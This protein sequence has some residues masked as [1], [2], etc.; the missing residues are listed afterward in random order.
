M[1][2]W[3]HFAKNELLHGRGSYSPEQFAWDVV[4]QAHPFYFYAW[5]Q[6]RVLG[7]GT[8]ELIRQESLGVDLHRLGVIDAPTDLPRTNYFDKTQRSPRWHESL[9]RSV[10]EALRA[11][12]EEDAQRF[13]YEIIPEQLPPALN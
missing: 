13:N 5:N 6:S 1:S 2:L 12:W 8:F 10:I 7:P 11:W 4:T 3:G 9:S